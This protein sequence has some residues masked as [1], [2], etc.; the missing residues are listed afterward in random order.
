MVFAMM[1]CT[2]KITNSYFC[3]GDLFVLVLETSLS[4]HETLSRPPLAG[5]DNTIMSYYSNKISYF[6]KTVLQKI[7]DK[8]KGIDERV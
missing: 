7:S 3:N 8:C 6:W 4:T 5:Y 1:H 2:E